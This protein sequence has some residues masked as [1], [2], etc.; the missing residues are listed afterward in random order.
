MT[1]KCGNLTN[2]GQRRCIDRCPRGYRCADAPRLRS[3]LG[4]SARDCMA[5]REALCPFHATR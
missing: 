2:P 5:V 1:R 4:D 3:E